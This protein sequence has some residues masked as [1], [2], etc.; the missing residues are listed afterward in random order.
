[1]AKSTNLKQAAARIFPPAPEGNAAYS[2]LFYGSAL[3]FSPMLHFKESLLLQNSSQVEVV[4]VEAAV[5]AAAKGLDKTHNA[6]SALRIAHF[7][8]PFIC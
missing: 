7:L 3:P 5:A 2:P 8:A 4:L 6:P 1:M